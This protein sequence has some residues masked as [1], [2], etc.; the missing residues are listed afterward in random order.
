MSSDAPS[1]PSLRT[2]YVADLKC[3]MCGTV[4]GSIE[5]EQSFSAPSYQIRPVQLRQ[6]GHA[7][8]IEVLNWRRL[9]CARCNGLLF[10]DEVDT[11]T[12]RHEEYNWLEERPRRGR[13]PKRL[14]EQRRRERELLEQQQAA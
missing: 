5:S 12:R 9:H 10:V 2:Y 7:Q 13:P 14:I 6:S 1:K 11:V 3:Y 4:A 8:P